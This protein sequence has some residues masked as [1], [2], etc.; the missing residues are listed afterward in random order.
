M[1]SARSEAIR[2]AQ[3]KI[4]QRPLYLDTETTGSSPTDEIVQIGIIDD[5][6]QVVFE[7]LVKPVGKV[8]DEARRV[9]HITDEMLAAAP[10]WLHIW[11]QVEALLAGQPVGT[12]N[13]DFDVRMISQTNAKFRIRWNP[14][15]ASFF[16]IM[17]LY[18]QFHGEWNPKT[19]GYRWQSLEAAGRQCGIALPNSHQASDD[20]RLAR[21][22]LHHIAGQE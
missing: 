7:S 19:G 3:E 6:G 18:A 12:Y 15:N 2:I 1:N 9:H 16:C 4:A 5:D 20:A 21:A 22:V 8:Q 14:E 10:R 17:K 11:P 13:A